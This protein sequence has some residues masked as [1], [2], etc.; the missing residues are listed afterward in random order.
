MITLLDIL[1]VLALWI[2]LAAGYA[3]V[4]MNLGAMKRDVDVGLARKA[5]SVASL[6]AGASVV[7]FAFIY[8]EAWI[9]VLSILVTS[10]L[11]AYSVGD[12]EDASYARWMPYLPLAEIVADAAAV[13]S[14][15]FLRW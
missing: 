7:V 4:H 6:A 15:L 1:T 3:T 11:A 2:C 9:V 12:M 5:L 10:F 8:T 14:W 13:L